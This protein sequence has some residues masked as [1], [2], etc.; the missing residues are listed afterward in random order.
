[1]STVLT[2]ARARPGHETHLMTF[3]SWLVSTEGNGVALKTK[4]AGVRLGEEYSRDSP[5][6]SSGE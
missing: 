1:M 4:A 3:E 2:Q 6:V 5:Q